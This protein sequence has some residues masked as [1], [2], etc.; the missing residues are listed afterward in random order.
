M[1]AIFNLFKRKNKVT[2]PLPIKNISQQCQAI[3]DDLDSVKLEDWTFKVVSTRTELFKLSSKS[4]CIYFSNQDSFFISFYKDNH[5]FDL[6]N[7]LTGL[8]VEIIYDKCEK[9]RKNLFKFKDDKRLKE[10]LDR[11][12]KAYSLDSKLP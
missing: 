7:I 12:N 6:H 1:F 2:E 3:L 9:I 4:I 5:A 8:E 10:N 11:L